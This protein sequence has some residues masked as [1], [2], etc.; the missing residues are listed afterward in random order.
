M[1]TITIYGASDDLLEIEGDISEEF[2]CY[3]IEEGVVAVSDGTLL[4]V[5]YDGCWRINRLAVGSATYEHV[6]AGPM[7]SDSHSD[8]VTL[9]GDIA[10]VVFSKRGDYAPKRVNP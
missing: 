4:S 10:W 8:R 7:D 1:K 9:A 6:P 5:R 2:G 3:D